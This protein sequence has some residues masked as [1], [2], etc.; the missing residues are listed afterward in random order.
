[1]KGEYKQWIKGGVAL[2]FLG[3]AIG[4]ESIYREPLFNK[5]LT[6]EKQLQESANS[7]S[8]ESFFSFITEFGDSSAL[9]PIYV[10]C[11]IC[12]PLNKSFLLISVIALSNYWTNLLKMIY[13]SPRPFWVDQTLFKI[14]DGGYGNPSGHA[15]GSM[16]FYLS[17][18]HVSTDGQ[19]FKKHVWLRVLLCILTSAFIFTILLSRLFFAVHSVNQV[20]YGGSLGAFNYFVHIHVF[21]LHKI[22]GENFFNLFKKKKN[23]IFFAIFFFVQ[24]IVALIVYLNLRN[25]TNQYDMALSSLCPDL[26]TY[27]KYENDGFAQTLNIFALVG[28]YYG[29]TLMAYL[30]AK[31]YSGK[32][33]EINFWGRNS[34]VLN[35]FLRILVVILCA[36]PVALIALPSSLDLTVLFIFKFT[37][38]YM[39]PMFLV[40]GPGVYSSIKC[41]I[42]NKEIFSPQPSIVV[43]SK[44]VQN[45]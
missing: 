30:S 21:K 35:Q 39:L 19:F 3:L 16:A 8:F 37:I 26:K 38:A 20:L 14:C 10:L 5:S 22:S 31:N 36:I 24:F 23:Q 44:A 2:T 9:I 40:Y 42:V 15:F 17:L 27:K 7:K 4:L 34:G 12:F 43:T 6:W 25:E 1:M 28:A 11:F 32:E 41:K 45:A 18:W 29:C 33:E 13:H